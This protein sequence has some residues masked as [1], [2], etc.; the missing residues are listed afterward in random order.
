MKTLS[1]IIVVLLSGVLCADQLSDQFLEAAKKGDVTELKKLLD[2]GVKVD[3][4]NKYGV[5]ALGFAC[6]KGHLDAVQLLV[7]R[8][9]NVNAE[10]TFYNATPISWA[11]ENGHND[12]VK[13]LLQKGANPD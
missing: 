8:G 1:I 13:Y 5:T 12:I 2:Q 4:T 9:A 3:S 7:E 11:I 6:S 10:D